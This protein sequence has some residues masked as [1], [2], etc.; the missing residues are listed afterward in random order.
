[1]VN[2]RMIRQRLVLIK[3]Y[4]NRLEK[5]ARIPVEDFSGSDSCAAVESYLRRSLEAM[6]DIGRH[7][8]AKGGYLELAEEYKSIAKGLQELGA[9]DPSLGSKMIKMAG[10]RNRMV[11]LYN[12]ITDD[13]L[14]AIIG[15]EIGDIRSFVLQIKKYLV[16][17]PEKAD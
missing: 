10:Y 8:V 12:L 6:F 4:M 15:H 9:I 7:L 16:S 1:M 3:E 17:L 11:H 5:L 14:Y 2:K 13:E